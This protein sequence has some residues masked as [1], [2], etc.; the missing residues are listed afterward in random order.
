[1]V[2]PLKHRASLVAVLLIV[3]V[4][5]A[6]V[7][8][9][10]LKEQSTPP[11][12]NG[13][14]LFNNNGVTDAE[15]PIVSGAT[16]IG[17]APS[18]NPVFVCGWDAIVIRCPLVQ[19]ATPGSSDYAL[20][21]RNIPSGTQ[22]VSLASA[23]LPSNAAQ[24]TGGNLATLAGIVSAAKAAVKTADGDQV[25]LGAKADAKSTST[26]TTP[27]TIMQV[28][29]E[30][31]FMEQTPASRAVTN[32]GTFPVQSTN[33][34]A[35]AGTNIGSVTPQPST[36]SSDATSDCAIV[37]A[38]STNSTN[39]KGSAGNFYGYEIYNTTTTVYYLRLYNASG[40]P[41]CSSATGFI[42]SIPIPPAAAAGGVGGA[43]VYPVYAVN[44]ST[45]IAF[46]L[47]GGS[48]STDNTNAAVGIFGVIKYK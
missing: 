26:D 48:S 1:M 37:S 32:A 29:K 39:C 11:G 43:V 34:A 15:D 8:K 27:I 41:T 17:V 24:E 6:A 46:C 25:T 31:S 30:I 2:S 4:L 45:G 9:I 7:T 35:A 42:R 40:A 16:A 3:I 14:L 13:Q 44:Y 10:N 28:L 38:A 18:T 20:T 21:V 36:S 23:P 22:P 5:I 47:T 19:N 12:S 33:Q